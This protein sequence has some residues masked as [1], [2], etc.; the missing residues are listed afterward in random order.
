MVEVEA[1]ILEIDQDE[2]LE[3]LRREYGRRMYPSW[4]GYMDT[5]YFNVDHID[6]VNVLRVRKKVNQS[7]LPNDIKIEI[8]TKAPHEDQKKYPK[9]KVNKEMEL[10][11]TECSTLNFERAILFFEAL[12]F[13][14]S[15]EFRKFRKSWGYTE[16]N[17]TV[18]T[19]VRLEFDHFEFRLKDKTFNSPTWVEIETQSMETTERVFNEI[20]Y[21]LNTWDSNIS[22]IEL[23]ERYRADFERSWLIPA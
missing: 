4:S 10:L 21:D 5:V 18:D 19:M 15:I 1:K 8:T 11:C 17:A 2:I 3:K 14:K 16:D 12:G 13:E 23:Y 7:C 20:G 6:N 22:T 9:L